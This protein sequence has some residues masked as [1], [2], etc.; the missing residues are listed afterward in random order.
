M[1]HSLKK[2]ASF[3]TLNITLIISF[4]ERKFPFHFKSIMA[5][6]FGFSLSDELHETN[7]PVN[8]GGSGDDW[9]TRLSALECSPEI[10]T[11]TMRGFQELADCCFDQIQAGQWKLHQRKDHKSTTIFEE[12]TDLIPGVYEGGFALWECTID[13]MNIITAQEHF[14]ATMIN[15]KVLDLGCGHGFLGIVALLCGSSTVY[16]SDFNEEVLLQ[17][18]GDNIMKNCPGSESKALLLPGDWLNLHA[19]LRQRFDSSFFFF[20]FFFSLRP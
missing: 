17:S 14:R 5:F 9:F 12:G 16:F 6:T 8:V 1:H 20:I 19:Y 10:T 15:A 3:K 18:T 4:I 13:L 2:T 7:P 11:I